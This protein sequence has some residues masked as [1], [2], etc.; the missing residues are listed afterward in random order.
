M[1]FTSTYH[2]I[3]PGRRIVYSSRLAAEGRHAKVSVTTVEF[4]PDGPGC[5]PVLT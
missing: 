1:T 2:D 3:V 4:L 5:R